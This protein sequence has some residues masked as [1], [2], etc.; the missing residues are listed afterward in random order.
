MCHCLLRHHVQK[1]ILYK[2]NMY[3]KDFEQAFIITE[4]NNCREQIK[5]R[6]GNIN[7]CNMDVSVNI[8]NMVQSWL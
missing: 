2:R 4:E 1:E 7:W 6:L 5:D 3:R 8:C